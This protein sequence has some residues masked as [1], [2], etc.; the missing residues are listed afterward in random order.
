[1]DGLTASVACTV[2]NW[3]GGG[4]VTIGAV[5][6][7]AGGAAVPLAEVPAVALSEVMRD[8]DL[9]VSVAGTDPAGYASPSRV[10]SRAQLLATLIDELGLAGVRV[11][12]TSAV[13]RGS[14]ATYRVHLTSGSI[15]VEPG[16]YLCVVPASFGGTTH[17]RLFLPFADEDRMT[18]VILSKVLLLA[19][20]E[21]ITDP[22][23][24]AQLARLAPTAAR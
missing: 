15:H 19:E 24:L 20:D 14:R 6:F 3:F 9:V 7:L 2:R 12:G 18:S 11:D 21:K 23:I 16:G 10:A 5:R 17:K 1:V 13:V 4:D 22:S 8:L